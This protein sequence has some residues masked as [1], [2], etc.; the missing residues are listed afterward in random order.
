MVFEIA[1]KFDIPI[2]GSGG[3]MGWKDAVEYAMAGASMFGVCTV[4]HLNGAGAYTKLIK[5]FGKYLAEKETS[6][7]RIRG[8][9]LRRVEERKAKGLQA[10]TEPVPPRIVAELCNACKTCEKSCIYGAITVEEIVKIDAGLC[11]GCGLCADVC[12]KGALRMRYFE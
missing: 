8:L 2:I 4:G 6:L 12:P 7:E 3:I 9:S 5:D 1:Q 11:Y 10:I